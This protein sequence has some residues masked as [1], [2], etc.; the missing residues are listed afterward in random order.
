MS[1]RCLYVAPDGWSA[2]C[3]R[4][5]GEQAHHLKQVLRARPGDTFEFIDGKGRWAR[6]VVETLPPRGEIRCRIQ[7][8]HSQPPLGDDRW[9]LLQALVRFEKFEWIL[10]KAA[11]L[12]VTRIIPLQTAYTEAKWRGVSSNR[13]E[14]WEKILVESLKQSRRLHLPVVSRPM[15]FD[16]AIGKTEA[17][18]KIL[19][20]EKPGTPTLKSV[21]RSMPGFAS[22]SI[23]T[24]GIM[25][26]ALA[27]GP[28]GGWANEEVAFAQGAGYQPV[29]L[30][31]SILRSETAAVAALS[32]VRYEFED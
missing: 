9:I 29:S 12:G 21:A 26:V 22:A 13:F 24:R 4:V 31:E 6:A 10:E 11:E 15:R 20:S 30:G 18:V 16:Q 14:R 17:S 5:E 3:V 1:E 7:E 2:E 27:I 19:L 25:K 32:I 28:E 23:Q 8:Q